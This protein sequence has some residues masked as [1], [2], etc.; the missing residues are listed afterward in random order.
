MFET[1]LP[2]FVRFTYSGDEIV[3]CGEHGLIHT[4]PD[5]DDAAIYLTV[6]IKHINHFPIDAAHDPI[7]CILTRNHFK[8]ASSSAV[9]F[10][11]DPIHVRIVG[12]GEGFVFNNVF[13]RNEGGFTHEALSLWGVDLDGELLRL[14][15]GCFSMEGDGESPLLFTIS[16]TAIGRKCGYNEEK[17]KAHSEV[18]VKDGVLTVK[19]II[20]RIQSQTR[21]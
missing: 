3:T 13:G 11:A 15:V 20:Y 16:K 17:D 2:G 19:E 6:D 10:E 14:Q 18:S 1:S 12:G 9:E 8:S 5:S 4:S 21:W 7:S